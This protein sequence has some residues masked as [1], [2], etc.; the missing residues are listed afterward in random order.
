MSSI[1]CNN[2]VF[3]DPS[4]GISKQCFCDQSGSYTQEDIDADMKEQ[5]AKKDEEKAES[6]VEGALAA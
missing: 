5:E 2:K 3:G 6:Q 4:P 1:K